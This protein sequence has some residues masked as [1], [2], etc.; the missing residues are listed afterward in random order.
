MDPNDHSLEQ[1]NDSSR[2]IVSF[3]MSYVIRLALMTC[4]Q[5]N[6]LKQAKRPLRDTFR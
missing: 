1:T 2:M 5:V 6:Y 4:P 3:K